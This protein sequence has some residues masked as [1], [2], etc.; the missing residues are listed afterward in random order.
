MI[1]EEKAFFFHQKTVMKNKSIEVLSIFGTG[2]SELLASDQDL[3]KRET[4]R[5]RRAIGEGWHWCRAGLRH[6]QVRKE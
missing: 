6:A 1:V 2:G 3:K 5:K 4:Q